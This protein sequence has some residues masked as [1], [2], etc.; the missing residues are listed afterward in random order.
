MRRVYRPPAR[1]PRGAW[2]THLHSQ[3]RERD[4]SQTQ[5]FE[6]VAVGLG[7]SPKSR[8]VYAAIDMGDRQPRA[9]EAEYLASVFGWPPEGTA[10]ASGATETPDALV[11]A[12]QAQTAAINALVAE[13]QQEREDGRDVATAFDR[14]ASR[15]LEVLR[16]G[17]SG[18]PVARSAP[19]GSTG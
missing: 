17:D 14:A 1:A 2:A 11:S 8:A 12:L 18:A 7:L 4:L 15:L 16:P 9:E 10:D 19:R 5:A 6:L 13:L 3:R